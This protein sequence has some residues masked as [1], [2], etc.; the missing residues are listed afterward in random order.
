[1]VKFALMN[2]LFNIFSERV[3]IQQSGTC[4]R[5]TA[6]TNLVCIAVLLV[7]LALENSWIAIVVVIR[8]TSC[9]HA[10]LLTMVYLGKK[11]SHEGITCECHSSD[12]YSYKNVFFMHCKMLFSITLSVFVR[13][14]LFLVYLCNMFTK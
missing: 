10:V 11:E 8:K 2:Y 9:Y 6:M 14:L 5:R 1:M 13:F 7:N 3:W 12:T 4:Q